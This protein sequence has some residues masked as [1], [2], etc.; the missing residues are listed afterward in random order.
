M[1]RKT[2]DILLTACFLVD[3]F[4]LILLCLIYLYPILDQYIVM[5]VYVFVSK[6]KQAVTV[7]LIHLYSACLNSTFFSLGIWP[8]GSVEVYS[9]YTV[10]NHTA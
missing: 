4:F 9:S 2:V 3:I 1:F 6:K 7:S 10:Q 5:S 8:A